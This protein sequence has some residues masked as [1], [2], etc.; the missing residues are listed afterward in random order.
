MHYAEKAIYKKS[1]SMNQFNYFKTI[2]LFLFLMPLTIFGQDTRVIGSNLDESLRGILKSKDG[3]YIVYGNILGTTNKL[4]VYRTDGNFNVT[5]QR[6]YEDANAS[7]N[8]NSMAEL[9]SGGLYAVANSVNTTNKS[10]ILCMKLNADLTIDWAKSYDN[11]AY[12]NQALSMT[13][14]ADESFIV[15]A[16]QHTGNNIFYDFLTLRVLS[17][18]NIDWTT[19]CGEPGQT[20]NDW[21]TK[22]LVQADGNIL[23]GGLSR[24]LS[25]GGSYHD[26]Y[27]VK[28]NS[29]TGAVMSHQGF[30]H[31]RNGGIRAIK[32]LPDGGFIFFSGSTPTYSGD[33]DVLITRVAA[34]FSLIFNRRYNIDNSNNGGSNI[35]LSA[36]NTV[37]I[38]SSG[39]GNLML[40][41]F[42]LDNGDALKSTKLEGNE[43]ESYPRLLGDGNDLILAGST[44]SYNTTGTINQNDLVLSKVA[45]S[46]DTVDCHYSQ[47]VL[48]ELPTTYTNFSLSS[49]ANNY[50]YALQA[51]TANL[52]E[53]NVEMAD[54]LLCMTT[55]STVSSLI[56]D[57]QILVYPTVTTQMVTLDL[58]KATSN[59]NQVQLLD[60]QGRIHQFMEVPRALQNL[61]LSDLPAGIYFVKINDLVK[62]VVKQ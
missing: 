24:A 50:N 7:I 52:T 51:S 49:W 26:P 31:A 18:G 56:Q 39:N 46:L 14:L 9:P 57:T 58:T 8:I 33:S 15:A 6:V 42:D 32:Q 59:A 17:N 54:L 60:V 11:T 37:F 35:H 10:A 22:V 43:D 12:Y 29:S 3:G 45:S 1:S 41:E 61:D 13:L 40:L 23:L 21:P 25:G 27:F 30:A 28:L 53:S 4:F 55:P 47:P 36:N 19:V 44:L 38:A 62:K 34:D 20:Q 48:S 16:R 5:Q 2:L